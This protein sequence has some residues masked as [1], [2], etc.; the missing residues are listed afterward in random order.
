M[1]AVTNAITDDFGGWGGYSICCKTTKCSFARIILLWT[2][3]PRCFELKGWGRQKVEKRGGNVEVPNS[4]QDLY[5]YTVS[6]YPRWNRNQLG[7]ILLPCIA[8][9]TRQ[10]QAIIS[11]TVI[12]LKRLLFYPF[13]Q[14]DQLWFFMLQESFLLNFMSCVAML[15]WNLIWLH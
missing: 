12:A 6:V 2:K 11:L 9:E 13:T 3:A 15:N 7:F 1:F 10:N 4:L 14:Q 8:K 5:Y